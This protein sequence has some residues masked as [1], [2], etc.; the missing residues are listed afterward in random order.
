MTWFNKPVILIGFFI[1][2]SVANQLTFAN[3]GKEINLKF[4]DAQFFLSPVKNISQVKF[5]VIY[6]VS[7]QNIVGQLINGIMQIYADNGTLIKT[8]SIPNGFK[9]DENGFQQFVTSMPATSIKKISALVSFTD[10]NKTLLL[11]N[12]VNRNLSLNATE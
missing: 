9:V 5:T 11:S 1:I 7:D 3:H 10:L 4:S 12:T 6:S 8:T 2:I